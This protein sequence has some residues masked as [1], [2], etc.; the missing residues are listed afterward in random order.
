MLQRSHHATDLSQTH[1]DGG[2]VLNLVAGDDVD[3]DA[4]SLKAGWGS[5]W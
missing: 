5:T 1:G 3:A 4:K 2:N